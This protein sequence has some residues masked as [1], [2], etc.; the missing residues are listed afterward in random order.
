MLGI[1][2][3]SALS[4]ITLKLYKQVFRKLRLENQK[5]RMLIQH[6]IIIKIVSAAFIFQKKKYNKAMSL[7]EDSHTTKLSILHDLIS[8]L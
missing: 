1:S 5:G 6:I 8:R 4:T 3:L 7:I 2:L